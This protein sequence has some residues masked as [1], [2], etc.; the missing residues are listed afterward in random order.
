MPESADGYR[1]RYG[2]TPPREIIAP[3]PQHSFRTLTHDYPSPICGWGFH[4]EYEIHLIT[5]TTGSFIAGDYIG[6]FGP[7][8]VTMMGANLPHD[9][10]SD[11]ERGVVVPD[12][13]A[14]IQF[15]EEWIRHCMLLLP[16][17]IDLTDLLHQ[18]S[19]GLQ[20]T[21]ETGMRA[22]D[23][24]LTITRS[25]GTARIS[26]MFGL[27]ALFADAPAHEK[28]FLGSE[29]LETG[30]D[31][32]TQTAMQ[33]GLSYI[34]ENLTGDIRLSKAAH[35]AFMSEPTFSK[36][37]KRAAGM[38]FSDMVKKLRIA[39]AQRLLDSTRDPVTAVAAASGY[40]NLANFNRQFLSEVGMTP[41]AYRN[42]DK[43]KKPQPSVLSLGT[44][45]LPMSVAN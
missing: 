45:A 37:F 35:L 10:V 25:H 24:I 13:D 28:E 34:F 21:G 23:L 1:G 44:K 17:T 29:L 40:N 4:P 41:T 9:W 15:T 12:R 3:H 27:L 42:L 18:S 14:V 22:A 38:T 36:Y 8:Q 31:P 33:T 11:L 43:D 5:Q 26:H 20:F 39:H 16:E 7:G 30:A 6:T 19:R 2:H 32:E